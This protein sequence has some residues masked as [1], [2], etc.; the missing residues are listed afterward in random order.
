[1][2][3]ICRTCNVDSEIEDTATAWKCRNCDTLND[4]Q[5][6]PREGSTSDVPGA[7]GGALLGIALFFLTRTVMTPAYGAGKAT[8]TAL[9]LG[10]IVF[11]I[12]YVG[13][14]FA[15]KR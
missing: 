11:T 3:V 9:I 14:K 5:G 12:V 4:L 10:V 6:Q 8:V 1:M 7:V 15:R 2:I 13:A